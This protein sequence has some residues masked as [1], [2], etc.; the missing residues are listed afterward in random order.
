MQKKKLLLSAL[1]VAACVAALGA[2]APAAHA[3]GSGGTSY[4]AN[5]AAVSP[6]APAGAVS[7]QLMLTLNGNQATVTEHVSGL[8][9][10]LPT[11]KKTL[12]A[13]GIPVA[14]AGAPF[15]HVQHIHINGQDSCPTASA[16]TNGDGVISTVEGQPAYGMIGTTLSVKGSTGASAATD[17]TVAP[18]GANF[19]Y[20]RT[21]TMNQTTMTAIKNNKAVIVVHGLNPAN[22]PKASLTTANSLG[23]TLPGATKKLAL[24]GTA[25]TLCGKLVASQMNTMPSGGV[26]TGG[27][28]TSGTQDLGL[29]Y[30]A[31]ALLLGAGAVF[32]IRR[33][34]AKQH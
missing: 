9:A 12:T 19:T 28:S 3:A 20:K 26:Q 24:I 1:P 21:F 2:G 23:V 34:Y 31:G 11:D 15:P 33:R 27:G 10:T 25:P 17:V 7:G 30:G 14:F 13:L 6:N 8:A 22:A 32:E 18:S 29:Y 16:D 4:Q 5:L